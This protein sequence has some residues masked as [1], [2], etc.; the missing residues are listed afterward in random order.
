MC[1]SLYNVKLKMSIRS[2]V[3]LLH[4]VLFVEVIKE[5]KPCNLHV[6]SHFLSDG[7]DCHG[8]FD[9]LGP[10]FNSFAGPINITMASR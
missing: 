8:L 6:V 7:L 4:E 1:A 9:K 2:V 5:R 3:V 10:K